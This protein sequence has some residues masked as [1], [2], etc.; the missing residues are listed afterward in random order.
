M[1]KVGGVLLGGVGE[2]A[3]LSFTEILAMSQCIEYIIDPL[4]ELSTG[5]KAIPGY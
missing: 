3:I 5:M 2:M 4:K 1:V